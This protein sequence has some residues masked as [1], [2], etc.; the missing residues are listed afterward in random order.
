M[1]FERVTRKSIIE[2]TL[3]CYENLTRASRSNT[4][5]LVQH[6]NTLFGEEEVKTWSF[7]VWN[8][9][10]GMDFPMPYMMLYNASA[11]A[12]KSVNSQFKVG[13]PATA[14]LLHVTDFVEEARKISAPFDFVS[15]HMYPTDDNLCDQHDN[16]NP[17][18]LPF[19]V[20]RSRHALYQ[21]SNETEFYLT[22]YNVGCCIG[23]E[24]FLYHHISE[25]QQ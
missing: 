17:D 19:R 20:N 8:E 2:C 11:T 25:K 24:R 9:L 4:G 15:T 14:R 1:V 21:L 18:C 16:W 22:E 12:V 23:Y 7:E 13:G 5:T 3:D 6:A 10:W